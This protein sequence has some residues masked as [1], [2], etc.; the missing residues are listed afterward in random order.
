MKMVGDLLDVMWIRDYSIRTDIYTDS[1]GCIYD[2]GAVMRSRRYH[3]SGT[4]RYVDRSHIDPIDVY[5]RM[6]LPRLPEVPEDDRDS[7]IV[8]NFI[9]KIKIL[10]F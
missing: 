5:R 2:R 8:Y 1:C 10:E 4:Q 6:T 9:L 3:I 7:S